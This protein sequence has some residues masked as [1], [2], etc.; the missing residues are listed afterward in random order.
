MC[1]LRWGE[2]EEEGG[3]E[4]FDTKMAWTKKCE[5]SKK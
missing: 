1:L 5:S 3:G 2:E 4:L